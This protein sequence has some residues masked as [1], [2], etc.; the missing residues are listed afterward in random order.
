M[1]SFNIDDETRLKFNELLKES[2]ASDNTKKI[3]KLKHSSKIKEQVSIMMDIKRKYSRLDKKTQDKMIDTQCNWLFT[4]YFNLFNKLKKDELDIQILGQFV[5]ALKAVEDG[6]IDQ[7]EASVRVGQ[8]LKK[9]YIDSALKKDKK[10]EVKRE[11]QRKKK[12]NRKNNLTWSQFK[13]LNID[14]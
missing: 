12:N 3:R 4:H 6:D 1:S 11:R 2:D 8:I 9:L 10:E 5:N 14:V 13:K 7:H